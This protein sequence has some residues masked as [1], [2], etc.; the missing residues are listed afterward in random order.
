VVPDLDR[1]FG[2]KMCL[3]QRDLNAITLLTFGDLLPVPE[4]KGGNLPSAVFGCLAQKVG[5]PDSRRRRTK[6][7]RIRRF[8]R[9]G[10]H[11]ARALAF[12]R[13][14]TPALKPSRSTL[15]IL[16]A[17]GRPASVGLEGP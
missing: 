15:R 1:A 17:A 11:A 14:S 5:G 10:T 16:F 13:H 9:A 12:L 3:V 6:T 2:V 8:A 7:R 4:F